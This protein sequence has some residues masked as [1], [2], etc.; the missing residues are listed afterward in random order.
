MWTISAALGSFR[1]KY[2]QNNELLKSIETAGE[3]AQ[4]F[5]YKYINIHEVTRFVFLPTNFCPLLEEGQ[6]NEISTCAA[7][8]F[9]REIFE[10]VILPSIL[11]AML[12]KKL[13]NTR[14]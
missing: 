13:L 5:I 12:D 3:I 2:L 9:N 6:K 11:E 7:R 4:N 1:K 14:Q 8:K 10:R